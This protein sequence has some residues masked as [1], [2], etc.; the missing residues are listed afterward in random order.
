MPFFAP[1]ARRMLSRD[2]TFDFVDSGSTSTL[3]FS[4]FAINDTVWLDGVL[5][6]VDVAAVPE[7]ASLALLGLGLFAPSQGSR[8]LTP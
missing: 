3:R 6:N 1:I 7:P 4:D 8:R 5:D 2:F